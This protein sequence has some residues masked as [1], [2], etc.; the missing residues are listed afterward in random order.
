MLFQLSQEIIYLEIAWKLSYRTYN[1]MIKFR[2]KERAFVWVYRNAKCY[3]SIYEP[4]VEA[5]ALL[6]KMK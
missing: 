1:N 3:N 2:L 6:V 4:Q 5:M